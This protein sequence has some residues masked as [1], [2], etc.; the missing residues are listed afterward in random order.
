M[1]FWRRRDPGSVRAGHTVEPER[2][3]LTPYRPPQPPTRTSLLLTAGFLAMI[4]VGSILLTLPVAN[5]FG[6]A[7]PPLTA[8]FTATSA[9]CVTGLVVVDTRDYWS[10][11]GQ[12]VI[13]VLIQ[14]G[15]LG[16]LTSSTILL[17]FIKRR[18]SLRE[19]VWLK[20]SQ[21]VVP[22][23]GVLALVRQVTVVTL[24]LQAAG[25]I[26]LS[27][28][29]AGEFPLDWAL[30]I[31]LFHAVSAFNNAGFDLMGG[32]QSLTAY[33]EDPV[34]VLTV[35]TLVLFGAVSFVVL[36]EVATERNFRRLL[37]DT[38]LVL[39]TMGAILA[40]GTV[41]LLLIEFDN[42][43][44]LGPMGWPARLMNAFFMTT[45]R[46]SGFSTISVG[47]M[48]EGSLLLLIAMMYIGGSAGS[49]AGGIKVNTFAALTAAVLAAMRGRAEVTAF[50]RQIPNEQMSRALT[51][52]LIG[53][54]VIFLL[55]LLLTFTEE[56]DF[57]RV[58]FE[59]TSAFGIVGLST[60]I[61]PDL[62][63]AGKLMLIVT[64]YLGRIGPLTLALA[65][66][67]REQPSPYKFPEGRIR[68][69]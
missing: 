13:L 29:F 55:T 9:V 67:Q 4:L 18:L 53:L 20:E 19:R 17:M 42:P 31:G 64:M 68:I 6:V 21:G 58:L 61:T 45:S 8:L 11:F 12:A 65:L 49:L 27:L 14:L 35:A 44:T 1:R 36:A 41:S 57:L 30:W 43:D 66:A 5:R 25:A 47:T 24:S 26:V 38:K 40:I 56:F 15:G 22:L 63:S 23:G 39:V 48:M 32:F 60:G 37:M 28:R 69:G 3:A 46:T 54:M 62:S 51:V 34:V 7:T 2:V 16:F 50:G 52:A 10:P 33:R 59:A